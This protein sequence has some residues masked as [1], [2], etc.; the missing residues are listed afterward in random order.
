MGIVRIVRKLKVFLTNLY[1]ATRSLFWEKDE[2]V[3]IFGAWMGERFADN[4]RFLFQYLSENKELLGLKKVIWVTHSDEI[5][6][7]L[8]NMGYEAVKLGSP[9]SIHYHKIAKYHFCNNTPTG[10]KGNKNE[11]DAYY[12]FRAKRINLWHGIGIKGGVF[13]SNDYLKKKTQHPFLCSMNERLNDFKFYRTFMKEPG[14]WGDCYWLTTTPAFTDYLH[15]WMIGPYNHYLELDYPRNHECLKYTKDELFIIDLIKKYEKTA[16]YLPTYRED[17]SG[18]DF[19]ALSNTIAKEIN[20]V[21]WIQKTHSVDKVEE[22]RVTGNIVTLNSSFDINV[23]LPFVSVVVT[24]YSSVSIDALYHKKPVIYYV[25]D[26]D[27]YKSSDRGF[28]VKPEDY[29][30]GPIIKSPQEVLNYLISLPI[31]D[32]HYYYVR[33]RYW[34]M[35]MSYYN[36]WTGIK[37]LTR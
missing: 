31:L 17:K 3:V 11:L 37:E 22:T 29:I 2:S 21:L 33:N 35:G 24:D 10:T 5:I 27:T 6:N 23:L 14:G 30:A 15:K 9:E 8:H 32:E 1:M 28:V 19:G 26:W 34:N 4:P 13:C 25:P 18:F 16:L 7:M 36:I 12:S 20:N